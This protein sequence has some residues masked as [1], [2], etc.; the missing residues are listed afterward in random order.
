MANIANI[1]KQQLSEEDIK[2]QY[3]TP[4]IV[5]TAGWNKKNIRME[6]YFTD[7][8]VIFQGKLHARKKGKK[9][10]YLLSLDDNLPIAIVEAKDNNKP[11]GGGMQQ[12]MEYA[13]IL[14]LPFAYSSNGD[15]FLE[16]DFITNT[17]RELTLDEFPTSEELRKRIEEDGVELITYYDLY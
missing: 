1:A 10:D 12:A 14:D 7:G 4:A 6:Y 13:Q 15:G 17:E 16:H 8:R 5:E 3:I 9:A 2:F 11:L